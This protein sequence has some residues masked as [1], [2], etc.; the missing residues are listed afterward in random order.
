MCVINILTLAIN[1]YRGKYYQ[2]T[3]RA[4][5]LALTCCWMLSNDSSKFVSDAL[6]S[7]GS[8]RNI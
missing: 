1:V 2:Y 5:I 6:E 4:A 3:K 7:I 8:T